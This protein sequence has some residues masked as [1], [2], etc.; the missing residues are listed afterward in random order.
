ME[1]SSP[2]PNSSG[3]HLDFASNLSAYDVG[4]PDNGSMVACLDGDPDCADD[5]FYFDGY[6]RDVIQL[7][8]VK[9]ILVTIALIIVALGMAGNAMVIGVVWSHRSM[10]TPTNYY[11]VSLAVSDLMVITF[12]LPLKLLEYAADIRY[13]IFNT[14]LCSFLA[15]VFPTFVFTSVWTL[16]AISIDR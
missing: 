13:S 3:Y 1:S 2:Q 7:T 14:R 8:S 5:G 4:T 11:I 9:A 16:V 15:F 12:V 6:Y 10:R